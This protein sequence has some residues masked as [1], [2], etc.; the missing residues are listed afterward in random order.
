LSSRHGAEW[1][2][3]AAEWMRNGHAVHLSAEYAPTAAL[4]SKNTITN[5]R[6]FDKLISKVFANCCA[7]GCGSMLTVAPSQR[8]R[9]F[10]AVASIVLLSLVI[11]AMVTAGRQHDRQ[12][13][14]ADPTGQ[15]TDETPGNTPLTETSCQWVDS[16]PAAGKVGVQGLPLGPTLLAGVRDSYQV[17]PL[18]VVRVSDPLYEAPWYTIAAAVHNRS[19]EP[20][21]AAMWLSPA[22]LAVAASAG[23]HSV[24]DLARWV[25]NPTA[26]PEGTYLFAANDLAR[27]ISVWQ[28]PRAP[29][30]EANQ[31]ATLHCL[32]TL[33]NPPR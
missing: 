28:A 3:G 4:C 22:A 2:R 27:A 26:R 31:T 21:G 20:I 29:L 1:S 32:A 6:S 8:R 9:L 5:V 30:S 19:S 18:S 17:G 13:Q 12:I 7:W 16:L 14:T 10:L 11:G 15:A 25:A 24:D 23:F 33:G